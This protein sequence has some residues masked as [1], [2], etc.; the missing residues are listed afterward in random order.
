MHARYNSF[1]YEIIKLS[2]LHAK[3]IGISDAAK[4]TKSSYIKTCSV[5]L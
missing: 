1:P 3:F 5:A 2:F 4:D